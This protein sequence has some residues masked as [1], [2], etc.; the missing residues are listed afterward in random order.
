MRLIMPAMQSSNWAWLVAV[1][2]GA[3]WIVWEGAKNLY[4]A[5]MH[6]YVLSGVP[7]RRVYRDKDR[8]LFRNNV[9]AWIIVFPVIVAG[10]VLLWLDALEAVG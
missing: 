2:V 1:T 7:E 8:R 6:G 9:V 5:S 10:S 3:P 4:T